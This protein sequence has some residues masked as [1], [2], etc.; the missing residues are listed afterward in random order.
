M[1]FDAAEH[2]NHKV[3]GTETGTYAGMLNVL[4]NGEWFLGRNESDNESVTWI[5]EGCYT[6]DI[7]FT[8]GSN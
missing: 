5:V 6:C 3:Y 8:N 7:E 1:E 4:E 2:K